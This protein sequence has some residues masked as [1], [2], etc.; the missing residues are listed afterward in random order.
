MIS[1]HLQQVELV[2]RSIAGYKWR[3][4]TVKG[5]NFLHVVMVCL[6]KSGTR[7]ITDSEAPSHLPPRPQPSVL[8][9]R[10]SM[11]PRSAPRGSQRGGGQRGGPAPRGSGGAARVGTQVGPPSTAGEPKW[12]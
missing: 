8:L 11:P 1:C 12:R 6:Y 9:Y 10:Q 7:H 3:Y 5:S 2:I 4:H